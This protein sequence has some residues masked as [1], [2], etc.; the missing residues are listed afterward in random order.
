MTDTKTDTLDMEVVAFC[1]NHQGRAPYIETD[2]R[3]K[4]DLDISSAKTLM[5]G[6]TDGSK[7][8]NSLEG[9]TQVINEYL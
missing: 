2:V 5:D 8:I 6:Q 9:N 1:C 3:Q 4:F 7:Y